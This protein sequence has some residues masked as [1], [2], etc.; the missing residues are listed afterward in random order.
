MINVDESYH[1]LAKTGG[2]CLS[3][4]G[5]TVSCLISRDH[6]NDESSDSVGEIILPQVTKILVRTKISITNIY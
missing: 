3:G 4:S 5:D 1:K 2:Q 6:M